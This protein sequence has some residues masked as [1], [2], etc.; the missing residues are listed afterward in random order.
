LGGLFISPKTKN[1][2]ERRWVVEK[3]RKGMKTEIGEEGSV[4]EKFRS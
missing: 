2:G 4:N 1:K 3:M